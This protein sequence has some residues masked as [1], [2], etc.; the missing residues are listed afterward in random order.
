MNSLFFKYCRILFY[1]FDKIKC[2]IPLHKDLPYLY[3]IALV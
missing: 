1:K 2:F 3:L